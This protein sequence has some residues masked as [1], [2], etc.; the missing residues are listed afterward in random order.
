MEW[1]IST[2]E[3]SS[4]IKGHDIVR[5]VKAQKIR[6]LGKVKRMSEERKSERMLK[7]RLFSRRKEGRKKEG[8]NTNKMSGQCGGGEGQRLERKSRGQ[9]RLE[10]SCEGSQ[11]PQRAVL[12]LLMM[13]I[14]GNLTN[15]KRT[16]NVCSLLFHSSLSVQNMMAH[17]R[18]VFYIPE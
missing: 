8:T 1:K 9:S 13:M 15:F 14:Y 10:D 17:R 6:W 7:E 2:A 12:L 4:L 16:S 18:I 11:S 3:L 5:Y